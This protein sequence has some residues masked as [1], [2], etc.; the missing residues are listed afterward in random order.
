ML[1]FKAEREVAEKVKEVLDLYCMASGQQIN[2]DKY[3][4]CFSKRC[5]GSIKEEYLG[6][7]PQM[8]EH[9]RLGPSNI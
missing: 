8:R 3:F 6:T 5:P 2:R 1:L 4:V 7:C 9:P